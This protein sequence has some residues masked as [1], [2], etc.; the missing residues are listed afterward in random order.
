MM[1]EIC[2]KD[3]INHKRNRMFTDIYKAEMKER[4]DKLLV[5]ERLAQDEYLNLMQMLES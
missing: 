5:G 4:L 2:K 1:Y 3:I